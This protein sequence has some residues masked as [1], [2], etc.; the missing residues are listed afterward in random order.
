MTWMNQ[1]TRRLVLFAI[2]LGVLVLV[3]A[4][5]VSAEVTIAFFEARSGTGQIKLVWTTASERKNWGFNI[6]RSTDQKTWQHIGA[7]PSVKSQSPCIQNVMGAAY[8][9]TDPGLASSL[10]YYY[11]LQM[12]GQPCG[13]PNTYYEPV[14][15]AMTNAP[16]PTFTPSPTTS[17]SVPNTATRV[18]SMT[19]LPSSTIAPGRAP[20]APTATPA[21][22]AIAPSRTAQSRSSQNMATPSA[23]PS[24][25][26]TVRWVARQEP[27][28]DPEPEF[29]QAQMTDSH[30]WVRAGILGLGTLMGFTAIVCGA[31]ALLV[32]TR[33]RK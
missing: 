3:N 23:Q 2:G 19:R 28:K 26:V 20:L 12:V 16:T 31:L 4:A 10:R 25:S 14:V 21:R 29:A 27:T 1:R 17:I 5:R 6:E 30:N 11:R 33:F 24:P 7:E 8:E 15:S 22:I 9:F 18:P 32:F 13:D